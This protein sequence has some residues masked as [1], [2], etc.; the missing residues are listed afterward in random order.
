MKAFKHMKRRMLRAAVLGSIAA[1]AAAQAGA[2]EKVVLGGYQDAAAGSQLLA[3]DY[4]G[5]IG[6][7]ATHGFAYS[8]DEAAAST[9]LCVAYIMTKAWDAAHRECDLAIRLAHLSDFSDVSLAG[10]TSNAERV[11][12]AYSNRAV[13]NWLEARP[14]SAAQ[15]IARAQSLSPQASFVS[16]NLARLGNVSARALP[17]VVATKG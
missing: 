7:L 17:A 4:Q 2:G 1:A 9:N 11:A 12:L 14:Q 15:D 8:Q 5:V 10:R 3:G 16:Q 6:R 13:L